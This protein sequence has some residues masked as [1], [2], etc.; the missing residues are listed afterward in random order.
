MDSVADSVIHAKENALDK[1]AR[2][3]AWGALKS[4][5]DPDVQRGLAFAIESLRG[6]GK[7]TKPDA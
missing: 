1:S 4:L 3:G 7:V 6:I 5:G 2:L